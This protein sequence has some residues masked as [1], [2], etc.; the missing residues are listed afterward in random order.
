M[1]AQILNGLVWSMLLFL[2]ASGL[3]I[4]LSTLRKINF[5]HGSLF[6]LASFFAFEFLRLV[7][8]TFRSIWLA[9]IVATLVVG[10]VGAFI[11]RS[12]HF[13]G[14][15]EKVYEILL[16]YAYALIIYEAVHMLFGSG[17]K[18][19]KTPSYLA[20]RVNIFS[21]TFP[22]IGFFIIV[23]GV[24]AYVGLWFFIYK[25]RIG[26][27]AR[28]IS[29][30]EETAR[31]LGINT[32]RVFLF[33]FFLGCAVTAVGGGISGMWIPVTP[34]MWELALLQAFCIVIIGGIGSL[35]G[36]FIG[37]IGVGQLT[38]F[39]IMIEPRISMVM[40][41]IVTAIVLL[42]RPQGI[43]GREIL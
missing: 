9:I 28:G 19:I 32:N 31:T 25:T 18:F 17:G 37:S 27:L 14:E 13:L 12:L 42:V 2:V 21:T 20:G 8:P 16:T 29:F 5:A 11:E 33:V 40:I 38:S 3:T 41:F 7:P 39:S 23:V 34:Y 4:I 30:D 35:G 15:R 26:L 24:S 6:M 43:F 36:A 10:A 1:V 22:V